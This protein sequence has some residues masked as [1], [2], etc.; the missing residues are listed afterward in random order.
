MQQYAIIQCNMNIS[1]AS[2]AYFV[3]GPCLVELIAPINIMKLT[4]RSANL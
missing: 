4:E 1:V 3:L 2:L